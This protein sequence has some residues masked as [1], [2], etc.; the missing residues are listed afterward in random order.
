MNNGFSGKILRINLSKMAIS[1]IP[2]AKYA[3]WGGGHGMGSAV[4]WDLVKDKQISGFDPGN[5]ITIMTS[6][7]SGTLAPAASGRTEIQGIGVQSMPEWFTR[8]NVGGRFGPMLKYAGWD[9]IVIEGQANKP[10]WIDIRN[11]NVKICDASDLWGLDTWKTQEEIWRQVENGNKAEGWTSFDTNDDSLRTSQKPAV[12]AIGP[13]GENLCRI[14]CLIHDAGNA[15]GQGGFGGVWG[16]KNLKAISVIGSGSISVADPN[17]LI[18][19]R[20]WSKKYFSAD[21]TDAEKNKLND[22]ESNPAP[23]GF[24]SPFIPILFWQ[25]PA[26]ARPQACTGCHSGCRLRT[27]D[28]LGN[29]SSC[30][31]TFFYT[32]F[33]I[34]KHNGPLMRSALYLL[35]KVGQK[36]LAN[37]LNQMYGNQTDASYKATDLLQKYGIN[38]Y[39][40]F[41]GLPYLRA[42]YKMGVLGPGKDIDCELDFDQLGEYA[43]AEKLT[44]M[45]A[46]R[47]GIGDDIAEGFYRAA[48]RW[49]RLDEDLASGLLPYAYWGLPEHGYDPRAELEWGYGSILGDR[50]INEHDF[51]YLFWMP[52][53][54]RLKNQ[55]PPI[56]AKDI[57]KIIVGKMK[58][59]KPDERM[60]DYSNENMYSEHIARLVAWH[61]HYTRF[62]KESAMFCDLRYANFYN[63][64]RPDKSGITG[65]GEPRFYK[66]VTG[67]NLDFSDGI[68]MG[69]KIWN[70]DHA[71]WTLQGRHRDMVQFSPYI[72]NLPFSKPKFGLY[73]MPGIKDGKWDYI[74]LAGRGRYVEKAGFEEFKTRYYQLEGWEPQ[75]GYPTGKTLASLGL[76]FVADKLKTKKLLG[77]G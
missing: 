31:E 73:Y 74:N 7:L 19:A 58:P 37:G 23:G 16:A 24:D 60:L 57:V 9:G 35:E 51:N 45:I 69:R 39:E 17:D 42:L 54:A 65:E 43:F 53:I 33:D 76:D 38:A 59:F 44:K 13:A 26:Q 5:V 21:P 32:Q 11:D 68:R 55:D 77:K 8:S 29:E 12:L 75:T 64:Y 2:T 70:L 62:W 15:A 36:T 67:R 25:R 1:T 72:H 61:R 49:G 28:S 20:L 52:T 56:S 47:K 18:Q 66:A 30:A 22:L 14:A 71:I 63:R 4:F 27:G 6:P 48:K 3:H 10:V 40:L 34:D 50:D 41:I 46:F